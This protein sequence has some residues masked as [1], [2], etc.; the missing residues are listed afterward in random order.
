MDF[1]K[2]PHKHPLLSLFL[3]N[4]GVFLAELHKAEDHDGD[5][6]C[7]RNA[8]LGRDQELYSKINVD[9]HPLAF[10]NLPAENQAAAMEMGLVFADSTISPVLRKFRIWLEKKRNGGVFLL[11]LLQHE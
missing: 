6:D 4:L 11:D 2:S 3:P 7:N 8:V 5:D 10:R 1:Q 9:N